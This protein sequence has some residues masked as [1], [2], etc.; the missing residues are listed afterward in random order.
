MCL[1]VTYLLAT[2]QEQTSMGRA[3]GRGVLAIVDIPGVTRYLARGLATL[4]SINAS[5]I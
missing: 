5:E 1:S 2:V 3:L 4:W